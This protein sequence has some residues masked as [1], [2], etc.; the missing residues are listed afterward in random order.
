M[1]TLAYK[2][3]FGGVAIAII[4]DS[5]SIKDY[6]KKHLDTGVEYLE[7]TEDTILPDGVF[8]DAWIIKNGT[9]T[10]D[11]LKAKEVWLEKARKARKP[12]LAALDIDFMRAVESGNASLQTQIAAKKQALRDITSIELPDTLEAIKDVWPEILGRNPFK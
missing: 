9:I 12:M 1:K 7:I 6:C 10:I 11:M 5:I 2:N 4:A 3:N 8:S